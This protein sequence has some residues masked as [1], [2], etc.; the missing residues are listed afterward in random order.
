MEPEKKPAGAATA[1][2]NTEKPA[3]NL[4]GRF[5]AN[6][7]VS[8]RIEG[9][10]GAILFNADI[11]GTLLINPTGIVIWNFLAGPKSIDE[12][13]GHITKAF[14]KTTDSAAIRKDIESFVTELAPDYIQEVPG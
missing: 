9:E 14:S 6:P 4:N 10:A 2:N 12:I 7:V 11:D 8:C 1:E 5:A 3:I 13:V